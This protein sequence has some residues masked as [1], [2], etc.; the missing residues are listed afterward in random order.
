[1][2]IR[3]SQLCAKLPAWKS[4]TL[5]QYAMAGITGSFPFNPLLTRTSTKTTPS[6]FESKLFGVRLLCNHYAIKSNFISISSNRSG[7]IT[8][9][10]GG[11]FRSSG[12][13]NSKRFRKSDPSDE[14]QALDISTVRYL[15]L[16]ICVCVVELD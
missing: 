12:S 6:P 2:W 10:Y 9:R 4:H 13:G 1:M 16:Y 3:A 8:S 14:D 15:R 5:T 7:S 11:G